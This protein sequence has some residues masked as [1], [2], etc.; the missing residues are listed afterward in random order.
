[1]QKMIF[2]TVLGALTLLLL[3]ACSEGGKLTLKDPL[4][5]FRKAAPGS[6]FVSSSDQYK[7][8]LTRNY[9]VQQATG[10]FASQMKQTSSPRGYKI[11]YSVQGA[12]IS[13][14]SQ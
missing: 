12:V 4:R 14:E 7:S 5:L 3:G 11:Y 13:D 9:K 10:S 2:K 8:S 6:E 1:M